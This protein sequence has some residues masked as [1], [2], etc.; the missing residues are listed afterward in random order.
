MPTTITGHQFVLKLLLFHLKRFDKN[1]HIVQVF[2][3]GWIMIRID[4]FKSRSPDG[5]IV[6]A[7]GNDAPAELQ[8]RGNISRRILAFVA[9][10]EGGQVQGGGFSAKAAGPSP[11]PPVP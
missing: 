2:L 7:M 10:R 6:R 4:H 3:S 8:Q 11:L 9:F 1:D 5:H